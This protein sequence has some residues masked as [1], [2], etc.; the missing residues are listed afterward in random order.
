V[1][2][3]DTSFLVAA[4]IRE[5][6]AHPDAW[7]LFEAEIRGREGSVALAPQVLTE[8]AHV[9]TDPRRFER[10]LPMDE[11]LSIGQ[12]WWQARECRRVPVGEDAVSIFLDWMTLHRVGGKR[13]LD[14]LL[15]AS[16]RAAGVTRIATSDWRDFEL[17]DAFE[18]VRIAPSPVQ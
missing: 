2:G 5:H 16:Y 15:A 13:L 8:F 3:L 12:R 10:P 1:I 9:V 6:P 17:F 14:T 4:A 18:I 11:A 7:R